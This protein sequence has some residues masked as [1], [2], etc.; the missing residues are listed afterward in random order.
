M[1]GISRGVAALAVAAFAI[2]S[3]VPA[4]FADVGDFIGSWSNADPNTGGITRV[5]IN[6]GAGNQVTVQVFGRCHPSDCDWGTVA[7]HSY[8]DTVG[9]PEVRGVVATFNSGF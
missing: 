3:A 6:H 5:V 9:S 7:G 2:A 1:S 4:A 8:S